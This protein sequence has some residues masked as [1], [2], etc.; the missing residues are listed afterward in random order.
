MQ[1]QLEEEEWT[2]VELQEKFTGI[3]IEDTKLKVSLQ[4]KEG[5]YV[6]DVH[7][8]VMYAVNAR[9]DYTL[10]KMQMS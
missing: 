9:L 6:M 10:C 2:K 4:K 1:S 7:G 8:F 5:E 3:Q